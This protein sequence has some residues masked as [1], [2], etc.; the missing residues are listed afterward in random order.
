MIKLSKSTLKDEIINAT[1]FM[2]E[3]K[4][5]PSLRIR[6]KVILNGYTKDTFPKCRK[7]DEPVCYHDEIHEF[8]SPQCSRS[9]GSLSEE[10]KQKLQSEWLYEKRINQKMSYDNIAYELGISH[11]AVKKACKDMKLPMVRYN[12][13]DYATQLKLDNKQLLE[14]LYDSGMTME[15]IADNIGSSKA[16]VSIKM[17]DHGIDIKSPNSYEREINKRSKQE[18]EMEEFIQSLGISTTHSNRSIL[19]NGME[20]DVVCEDKKICF[21]YN[22][23]YSH[24]EAA[25]KDRSYHLNKTVGANQ[26]GYKLFHIFSDQWILN[27]S[28][29]KSVIASKLGIYQDRVYARK[30]KV[31]AISKSQKSTFMNNNHLQGNDKSSFEYGLFH[32]G[33]IVAAMTFCKS[34]YNKNYDWELS[35]FACKLNTNVV[36]G[37][38][39]LLTHFRKNHLGSVVSYADRMISVGDVYEKNGFELVKINPAGYRYV[40]ERSQKRLHRA[41]F[42]RAKISDEFDTRSEAE[43]MK[44]KG[45]HKV[46]DCGTLTYSIQ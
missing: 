23:V 35:R 9:Y 25:G 43:I 8:C 16:T 15:E 46:W 1:L 30:C 14:S 18:I 4:A 21:E 28:I 24:S 38:S 34:R 27:Q 2:N 31:G 5:I 19:P 6:C 32:D 26:K 20:I 11:I 33:E 37:F 41:N 13:S 17:N 29:T 22:G 36:G 44:S 42:M 7:C 39:K 10:V 45:F 3:F 12:E 40:S